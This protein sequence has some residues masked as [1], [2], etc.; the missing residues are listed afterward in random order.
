MTQ[1][2]EIGIEIEVGIGLFSSIKISVKW[3]NIRKE[4]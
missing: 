4:P 3:L 1:T 2:F